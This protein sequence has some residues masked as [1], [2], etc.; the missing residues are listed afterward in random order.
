MHTSQHYAV[1]TYIYIY[2]Y[3]YTHTHSYVYTQ[4]R[5][6]MAMSQSSIQFTKLFHISIHMCIFTYQSPMLDSLLLLCAHDYTRDTTWFLHD[7][8]LI[9]AGHIAATCTHVLSHVYSPHV[10]CACA[11]TTTTYIFFSRSRASVLNLYCIACVPKMH[12]AT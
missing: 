7:P 2:I 3:I 9:K 6:Y 10:S 12:M 11:W 8:M 5:T 4:I 1:Y